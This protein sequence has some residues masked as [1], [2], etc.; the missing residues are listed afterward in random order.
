M[1]GPPTVTVPASTVVAT[2]A[3]VTLTAVAVDPTGEAVTYAWEQL[4]GAPATVSGANTAALRVTAPSVKVDLTFR[5][6]AT[7]ASGEEATADAKLLVRRN[8]PATPLPLTAGRTFTYTV[9]EQVYAWAGTP[10]PLNP[11]DPQPV[12]TAT[13]TVADGGDSNGIHLWDLALTESTT[14]APASCT[15][16]EP[17]EAACGSPNYACQANACVSN[18]VLSTTARV[19]QVD[20]QLRLWV[21]EHTEPLLIVD[22]NRT[23]SGS[24]PSVFDGY[25]LFTALTRVDPQLPSTPLKYLGS[26]AVTVPGT[27]PAG[28]LAQPGTMAAAVEIFDGTRRPDVLTSYRATR[29]Y[30]QAGTGLVLF[31][32]E[33]VPESFLNATE[34]SGY[35]DAVL[36]GI[37]PPP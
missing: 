24:T 28:A 12:G 9:R 32:H 29:A 8:S 1:P 11:T 10:G 2:G 19:V 36:T 26:L 31:Q 22:P 15:A 30:Y 3:Q 20:D 37:S 5:V 33:G 25:E 13:L 23:L 27:L 7:D 17:A 35:R 6:T 4:T 18:K 14:G 16:G 21:D 34:Q